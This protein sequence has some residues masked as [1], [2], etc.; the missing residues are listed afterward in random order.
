MEDPS[1]NTFT[2]HLVLPYGD[3]VV[4]PGIEEEAVHHAE[5]LLEAARTL[6]QH[7]ISDLDHAVRTCVA[8]LTISDDVHRRS[9][10]FTNSGEVE[11]SPYLP[12]ES[13][14]AGLMDAATYSASQLTELLAA[15]GLVLGDLARCITHLGAAA[16]HSPMLDGGMLSL[17]PI[18]SVGEQ[19]VVFPVGYVLRAVRHLLL[20][21]ST[22][23]AVLEARYY[24]IAWA[25][26]QT[27]LRRM[28]IVERLPGFTGKLTLPIHSAA[29]QIDRDTV[30]HVVLVGDPFRNYRPHDLFQPSD[31][32]ALQTPLDDSYAALATSLTVSSPAGPH[33]F[34]LVVFEGLGNLVQLPSLTARTAYALSVAVSD[35][36][37][38]SYDFAGNPLGLLY[39]AQAVDGLF[40]RHHLG[41]VG[42]LDLFDAYCRH[43]DSFYLSDQ[44]PPAT[45]FVMPGGA[46]TVRRE[47]RIELATHGVRYGPE[48]IKVTNFYLDPTIRIFQST[49]L[50]REGLLNFVVEGAFR[51]WVVAERGGAPGINL[52]MLAE[53]LAYWLWQLLAHPVIKPPQA[54]VPLRVVIVA[55]PPL[56]VDPAAA[57]P[58]LRLLVAAA[59][60]T[61]VIQVDETF[62]AA[63]TTPDNT[64]ERTWM[65]AVLDALIEVMVFHGTPVPWPSSE[66]VVAEV[67]GD[68]AKKKISVVDRP[69]LLLDG[70]GLGRSRV[71]QEHQVS[72]SLDDLANDLGPE[73]PVGTVLE[74][75][76]AS[77]LLNAAVAKLFGQFT[78]LADELGA[79]AALP[80]FVQQH[81]ATV[82]RTAVRQ[83]NFEFTRRCFA[84][85]PVIVRR[86]Q[87][88]YGQN[89]NTAIASRFVLEYLATRQP[90]GSFPPTLERYDRLVA[91]ASLIHAFGTNSDLAFHEL[92]QVTAEILPSGRVA[93][94]RGA[95]EPARAA[96]EVTMF[97]DVTRESLRI[98]QAYL[99]NDGARDDQLPARQ[100]LDTAMLAEVGW[101][102]SD[103][104]LFLDGVSA[105]P[106]GA[107]GVEQR[108]E[109]EFVAAIAQELGWDEEAVRRC[110][111][112]F[113]LTGRAAFLRPSQPWR[114]EDVE[115]WRF[116]R[117]LSYLRRPIILWQDGPALRVIWGPR[118][119]T[120]AAHYLLDLLQT[121]R[122]R[123][124]STALRR[125][126]GDVNTRRGRAFNRQVAAFVLSLGLRPVQEQAKVFGAV[127]MRDGQGQDLGDIDV[128][129]V[130]EP[131]RRIYCVECKNF[132]VART[133]AEVHGLVEELEHGRPGER[134]IVERHVRRVDHVRDQLSAV[135][136]HF[137]FS[138]GG[139]VVEGLIVF[140]HDSVA[141]PL[142]ASPL[143]VLSFEQFAQRMTASCAPTRRQAY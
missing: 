86:L 116:N 14:L 90:T 24:A 7:E 16:H 101:T 15:R 70:R 39:F 94:A 41:P 99:G 80:Y 76:A 32:S 85:H 98:A 49:D 22:F 72:R 131:G 38:M 20:S 26:V 67:M 52:P 140:K 133:A 127:R 141:Y 106:G 18:V 46:G 17:Q 28:G 130:D 4:F 84:A 113:S 77:T 29:F 21:P 53:T 122:Y 88:E 103:L 118:A 5:Q 65:H 75:K 43:H 96:F 108:A 3:F 9:A 119:V 120:S 128:F 79:E 137:S 13:D 45:L 35:L 107:G 8:L 123:A 61:V 63:F 110:L 95:Y 58:G 81:E 56:P 114:R 23:T 47:R 66:A 102:L 57:L 55:V 62:T 134:S 125:V 19:Y 73:F 91:L 111:A 33:V 129:A 37:L 100:E 97:S 109:P 82:T 11:Q 68:P 135:L 87:E 121:G 31:L 74:G 115:P 104:L 89:N 124:R 10:R 6:R 71:V 60:F 143:P 136:E 30:L 2:E 78:R 59:R 36:D 126:L 93:T 25:G 64:P 42:M 105:L 27:S 40:R 139:W 54:D 12:G 50:L 117:G 142:S 138:P 83:L 34:S 92:S 48:T 69:T 1:D 132:A 51:C 112:E 44:A